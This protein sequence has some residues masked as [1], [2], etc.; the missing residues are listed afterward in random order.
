MGTVSDI[1]EALRTEVE[2]VCRRYL[3]NGRRSGNYWLVGNVMNEKGAS[4]H[5]RL[6]GPVSGPHARGKWVDEATGEYGDLLDLIK[7]QLGLKTVNEAVAEARAFLA[8]PHP[9]SGRLGISNQSDSADKAEQENRQAII[10]RAEKLF[11]ASSPIAG[12]LAEHYLQSRRIVLP[13][14]PALRFHPKVYYRDNKGATGQHPAL[15]GMISDRRGRFTGINRIWLREDGRGLADIAEPKKCQGNLYGNGVWFG[16]STEILI[17]GEGMETILSLKTARPDIPMVAALTANHLAAL[18]LPTGL[19]H[20]VI[21]R[22]N[23]EA[24][25]R[26]AEQLSERAFIEGI[27]CNI[28]VSRHDDFNTDLKVFGAAYLESRL[29]DILNSICIEA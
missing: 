17:A 27:R 7:E 12:T 6:T 25:Q 10:R 28:I 11:K 16:R 15:L 5:V 13:H 29:S 20:L 1:A 24:G 14:Q 26:A 21:A 8:L 18:K 9:P 2:A 23:D 3:S 19:K 4:M 22:D